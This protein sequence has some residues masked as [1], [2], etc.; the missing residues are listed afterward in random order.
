MKGRY[1]HIDLHEKYPRPKIPDNRPWVRAN[2]ATAMNGVIAVDGK[3][4]EVSGSADRYVFGFLRSQ[5]D[6]ILV[7]AS[8]ALKENYSVPSSTGSNGKPPQLIVATNSLKIPANANFLSEERRPI[9]ITS[10][11]SMD[12]QSGLVKQL[13]TVAQIIPIGKEE[14]N[15]NLILA[16]L[17]QQGFLLTLF[18]GGPALFSSLL[19]QHIVNELCL[20]IAPL[21]GKGEPTG[22]ANIG[23]SE[24]IKLSL[25]S[26]FQ[27]DD[28]VFCRYII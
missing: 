1:D 2:F 25:E 15:F 10:E 28:F 20:T 11:M 3:S 13:E 21:L 22:I 18:E 9:I 23:D 16:Q 8:T 17:R 5:C 7:G 24:S 12:K 27:I 4:K 14:I 6:S 26:S 19:I